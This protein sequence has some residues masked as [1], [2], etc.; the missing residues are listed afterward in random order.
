[1]KQRQD[2]I[3]SSPLETGDLAAK[4]ESELVL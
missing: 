1:V 4:E 2:S 3:A